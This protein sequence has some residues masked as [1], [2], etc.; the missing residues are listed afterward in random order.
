MKYMQL[1]QGDSVSDVKTLL[2]GYDGFY[3]GMMGDCVSVIVLWGLNSAATSFSS[4]R[5]MHGSG[6]VGAIQWATLLNGVPNHKDTKVFAIGG[7]IGT[8][9]N[10]DDE[11]F[12]DAIREHL[13]LATTV[14]HC[15]PCALVRKDGLAELGKQPPPEVVND[16][17]CCVLM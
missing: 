12:N 2:P 3:T 16:P 8:S 13:G 11:R 17:K 5:G 15:S 4:A 1:P 10:R 7:T 9:G 6:G 14:I